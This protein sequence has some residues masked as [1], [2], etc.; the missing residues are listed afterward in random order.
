M[1]GWYYELIRAESE[2]AEPSQ[3]KQKSVTRSISV[4]EFRAKSSMNKGGK[5]SKIV[6]HLRRGIVAGKFP[7]GSQLPVRRKLEKQFNAGPP[8]VQRALDQLSQE[9]FV[10]AE[11]TRGTFVSET[12]PH[13]YHY[14]MPF[15]GQTSDSLYHGRWSRF[16]KVLA[17]EASL[18]ERDNIGRI[19]VRY[20]VDAIAATPEYKRVRQ[21]LESEQ[22]AGII[23]PVP[24]DNRTSSLLS[25]DLPSVIVAP[26]VSD[27]GTSIY[28]DWDN[29]RHRA[30]E[31]LAGRQRKNVA[32]LTTWLTGYDE[33]ARELQ[34]HGMTIKDHWFQHVN[35]FEGA[36][37]RNIVQLMFNCDQKARP[38]ALIIQDD[39]LLQHAT[40]GLVAAGVRVPDDIDVI[41]HANFP[42]SES[43][44]LPVT[45]LGFNVRRIVHF[46]ADAIFKMRMGEPA[47]ELQLV[48][49]QFAD[50]LTLSERSLRGTF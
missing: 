34:Q 12:P 33:F 18:F 1:R 17:D 10:F 24:P 44:A 9:G 27:W 32:V 39:D 38:D 49:A 23:F 13:L 43:L 35:E 14:I 2:R 48:P 50:E 7:P 16:W 8:T 19:S 41:S 5:R 47:P 26:A 21:E 46:S 4:N 40:A 3:V 28:V 20:G 36:W 30:I 42:W 45:L 29:W 15:A 11:G 6:E 22:I 37:A 25:K 31:W